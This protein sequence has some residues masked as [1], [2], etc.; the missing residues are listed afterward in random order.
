[1]VPL[2][3]NLFRPCHDARAVVARRTQ[4]AALSVVLAVSATFP[5]GGAV[6][7]EPD[8]EQEGT[9]TPEQPAPDSTAD[10]DFNPGGETPLPF[11]VGAPGGGGDDD[12][13]DGP[14]VETDPTDDPDAPA[15]PVDDAPAPPEPLG[16]PDDEPVPPAEPAPPTPI[17]APA[18]APL[19]SPV[20]P[21]AENPPQP[22][23]TSERRAND[24]PPVD[25]KRALARKR[26][27]DRRARHRPAVRVTV[28]API[29]A[30]APVTAA[31]EAAPTPAMAAA[32]APDEDVAQPHA[33]APHNGQRTH[34]VKRGESLWTIAADLL[35]P[36]ATN[37]EIAA[38]V[39]RLYEFNRD[40]IGPDPNLLLT[41]TVLRLH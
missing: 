27:K 20:P 35:G 28:P 13:G 37:S 30:P 14:P 32:P 39:E 6:A 5:A 4:A 24:R 3:T 12:S 7:Q 2:G 18:P 34:T 17:P 11:D 31:P 33:G 26:A 36:S 21:A 16:A 9:A 38:E 10:P 23:T 1:M 40:R 25:D 15:I 22:D 19:P 41:G 29:V 8:Q